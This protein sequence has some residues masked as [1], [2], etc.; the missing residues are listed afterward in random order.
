METNSEKQSKTP[1]LSVSVED[2]TQIKIF[3]YVFG[4][5]ALKWGIP[6][7]E[8]ESKAKLTENV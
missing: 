2:Q 6:K 8:S 3:I 7:I 1:R 5:C 4:K